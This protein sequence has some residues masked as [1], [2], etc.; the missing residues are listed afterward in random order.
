MISCNY[1]TQL[2]ILDNGGDS[3]EYSAI[4]EEGEETTFDIGGNNNITIVYDNISDAASKGFG[5]ISYTMRNRTMF[6][7]DNIDIYFKLQDD[8]INSTH[9]SFIYL[10]YS[11]LTSSQNMSSVLTA[12][13]KDSLLTSSFTNLIR[14]ILVNN[15]AAS[16]QLELGNISSTEPTFN[17]EIETARN[18]IENDIFKLTS[19]RLVYKNSAN[20]LYCDDSMFKSLTYHLQ[21]NNV[22]SSILMIYYLR[23]YL[24]SSDANIC[25]DIL[26]F[27]VGSLIDVRGFQ[28]NCDCYIKTISEETESGTTITVNRQVTD[29]TISKTKNESVN[30]SFFNQEQITVAIKCDGIVSTNSNIEYSETEIKINIIWNGPL[31][32]I[33][34]NEGSRPVELYIRMSSGLIY[35]VKLN[36]NK[37]GYV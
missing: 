36:L 31:S 37:N 13:K 10:P 11:F 20:I 2:E 32:D 25:H 17:L 33:I 8:T 21:L 6:I 35:K 16:R 34:L 19:N 14:T 26:T 3:Y 9:R 4:I 5:N 27:N 15:L 23:R 22:S 30:Q 1:D 28:M 24:N 7:P 29:F 12:I 18:Y